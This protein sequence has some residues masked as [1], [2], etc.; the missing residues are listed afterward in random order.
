MN[1][2]S[3]AYTVIKLSLFSYNFVLSYQHFF[4]PQ[5]L[6]EKKSFYS[7]YREHECSKLFEFYPIASK[8]KPL[9]D[10]SF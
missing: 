10:I 2:Y 4:D 6:F 3:L 9:F 5:I 7:T 8:R 1:N